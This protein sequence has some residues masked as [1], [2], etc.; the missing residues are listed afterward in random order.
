M[1][2]FWIIRI[3]LV[4]IYTY[5]NKA[6]Q[7]AFKEGSYW[8]LREIHRRVN[9]IKCRDKKKKNLLTFSWGSSSLL[10][11]SFVNITPKKYPKDH[12]EPKL[13]EET[14]ANPLDKCPWSNR[15]KSNRPKSM[16]GR[17]LKGCFSW[18]LFSA[19]HLH[20]QSTSRSKQICHGG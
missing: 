13:K 3:F 9:Q 10:S 7:R 14:Q 4:Q 19:S 16:S 6:R 2:I 11:F 12:E 8:K 18:A 5:C 17:P 20:C 15:D 1:L